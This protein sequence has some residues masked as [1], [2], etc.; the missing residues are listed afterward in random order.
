MNAGNRGRNNGTWRQAEQKGMYDNKV[1]ST[2]LE[3]EDRVTK[4]SMPLNLLPL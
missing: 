4:L 3:S 1:K 2:G